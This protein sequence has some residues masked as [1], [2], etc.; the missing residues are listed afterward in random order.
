MKKKILLAF[1]CIV[2]VTLFA[3]QGKDGNPAIASSVVVNEYT[4]LT[5]NAPVGSTTITVAAS[6]LNAHG[7]F[8]GNLAAGDLIMIIQ[9]QGATINGGLDPFHTTWGTP[10]DSSWGKVLNYNNC[11]NYEFAEVN[12]VPSGTTIK[13]DCPLRFSYVDTAKVEVVRVPRYGSLTVN[14][15]G[16]ITCDAWD[17]ALGGIIAIE[18]Q[19]NT[20][21]N[22]GGAIS[23]SGLG[24]RGGSAYN[25]LNGSSAYGVLNWATTDVT[26]GKDKGEGIAGFEWSYDKYRG[27]YCEGAPGNAG[28]SGN[29]HNSGGGG[30]ANG[31]VVANYINGFGNPDISTNN[32]KTAW[33]KEF[34]WLP[35]FTSSGG[36]RGGYSFSSNNANPLNT[37]PGS[38]TWGGDNRGNY[39]GRGGR[40]LDYSTGKLFMAGGGGAGDQ[41]NQYGGAGGNGGGLVFLMNYG[42]VSGTGQI[43]ANGGNGTNAAGAPTGGHSGG[44]DAAGGA[45]GG[46]TIVVNSVGNI[47]GLT[48]TANGGTGGSQVITQFNIFFPD[49]EAEGPGGGGSGG[50]IGTSNL[51]ITENAVGGANGTSNA[52]PMGNFPPNG[53]T[54][55]GAGTTNATITNFHITAK[56]DTICSGQS[57]TLTATLLGNPPGGTTIEWYTT[58]SGGTAIATGTTYTTP[59]LFVTTTYWVGS[60]PG[61]YRI[62]VTVVISGS[63]SVTISPNKSICKGSSDSIK[64]TGGT[65]YSWSPTIGLS[66]PNIAN[67]NATPT[68]TTTYT[69]TVTTPCGP[70]K[71]SVKITVLPLPSPTIS[72]NNNPICAGKS[73]TITAGGGT[74]YLW[75]TSATTSSITVTPASTTT[76]TVAVSNGTCTKDTTIKITV[77]PLPVATISATVNPIC[78]GGS[79]KITAGGGTSYT[80]SNSATT[81]SI[82]VSPAITTN[83]SVIISNGTCT[84]DTNI[85]INVSASPTVTVNPSS[86]TICGNGSVVLNGV[87]ASTY[88]W[89][90]NTGLTCTNCVSPTASPTATTTYTVI[91]TSG[92]GCTDTTTVKVTVSGAIVATITGSD[93]IC[94][95]NPTVLTA[96]GGTTYK[97]NTGATTSTITVNPPSTT[98]YSAVVSSGGCKDSTTFKVT[99]TATP[100]VTI[101]ANNNPICAGSPT[102]ITT[103]G[104]GTYKWNTGATTSSITVSPATTTTYT[105]TVSN[106]KC[107]KDTTIKINVN[108]KPVISVSPP[109][110]SICPGGNVSLLASGA[111][112]YTWNPSTGLTCNNCPNPTATPTATTIYTVIGT[113]LGCTDTTT[114]TV[115]VVSTLTATIS[116]PNDSVCKGSF[117]TLT[118]GG[119]ATY[120]WNTGA[121]TASISV[122]PL[123]NTTYSVMVSSSGCKDSTNETVTVV[124]LPTV[125]AGSNV[126]ICTGGS[127]T[128]NAS[129][130]SSYTW[131]PAASL[132]NPN[133]FNPIATPTATTTYTVV[134]TNAS[135]CKDSAM[136]TVT[137]TSA[138]VASVNPTAQTICAGDS[139]LLTAGG[140][141]TYKWSNG[142]TTSTLTVKPG[143][144]TVYKVVV[145]SGTCKDSANSTI[146]V[147]PAPTVTITPDTAICIGNNATLNVSGGGTYLWSNSSTSSSITVSPGTTTT[148]TAQ[149]TNG[150]CTKDTTVTVTVNSTITVI[151]TPTK[152]SCLGK[153]D[154]LTASG[155]SPYLWSNGATTSTI[156]VSPG[157]TTVYTVT[158]GSGSCAA[159]A[160]DTVKIKPLPSVTLQG[161]QLICGGDSAL[162]IA[163]GG[164]KY[165]WNPGGSTTQ[166]VFVTPSST[167]TYTLLVAKNGCVKDTTITVVVSPTPIPSVN[168]PFTIC[169]GEA[170]SLSAFGGNTYLWTPY[171]TLNDSAIYNPLATPG[172]TTVYTVT[173]FGSGGCPAKDSIKVTVIPG[174]SGNACCSATIPI[175]GSQPL[176]VSGSNTGSTFS[177]YPS[178]G[179]SCTT[180]PNPIATPSVTTWYK[181]AITDTSTGCVRIDSVLITIE[182]KCGDVFVPDAFSPNG[183]FHNDVLYVRGDCIVQLDFNVFDRWGNKVFESFDISHGWDGS[184]HG[185]PMN[186]STYV[187]YLKATLNDGTTVDKKGNV[188]LVR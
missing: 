33:S 126:T 149:V 150:G 92:L 99:V 70:V 158:V 148:Y 115:T 109:N 110:P 49:N 63:S 133:I 45:G 82:T 129:G 104:G 187:W 72:A 140:G 166:S 185:L 116:P 174:A 160:T 136:V 31:G 152:V 2:S 96:S 122:N 170:A 134:G 94:S 144:T 165:L 74:S 19:N 78:P 181:V 172:S 81:S 147:N 62:P 71:D 55:G 182:N 28:G 30:G 16:N 38:G 128:L 83:Y 67:P 119:G 98:T 75:N 34:T 12:A 39:G 35:T 93:S 95:G 56:N 108:P 80:W 65:A 59:V 113:S 84:K 132:S 43:V 40:P 100:T 142:A 101:G 53:A 90:P 131:K 161:T 183:D 9:L 112:T 137:V 86:A 88:T 186:V 4:R 32:N 54:I 51:G 120:L 27:R 8:A 123:V 37:G 73:A 76:Y 46:G 157:S 20:V 145:T 6:T 87:G 118:A 162:L 156:I 69:V 1:F 97:W 154:T 26:Y 169:K 188:T 24:F 15:G 114:V 106:G 155:G 22:A 117:T 151:I 48:L 91:G 102:T 42:T 29:A 58:S 57:A 103:T 173:V 79:T 50:Y 36:G 159:S 184:Y 52:V 164:G 176:T 139:I 61:T 135:G 10:N 167:T 107:S 125:G 153:A 177:W 124:A 111:T 14:N 77:L 143:L 121:T 44:I 5:A 175:G 180:C 41:D 85:T 21:I 163:T 64:A 89:A 3:Q 168:G 179:L 17:S 141:G 146:T 11:G 130:A 138:V 18:V 127:T 68:V 60:C 178:L 66:N 105:A 47:S 7:R 13:L 25:N 171:T 23:A